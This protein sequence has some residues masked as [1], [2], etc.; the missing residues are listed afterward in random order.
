MMIRLRFL[1]SHYCRGSRENPEIKD[2][3]VIMM[4][5]LEKKEL[6]QKA[7]EL[8]ALD[9]IVKSRASLRDTLARVEG[10]LKK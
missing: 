10:H 5:N 2:T 4:S 3:P 9:Y 6:A 7:F 8:G 1:P